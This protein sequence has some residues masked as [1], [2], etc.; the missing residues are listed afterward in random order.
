MELIDR[1]KLC[2]KMRECHITYDDLAKVLGITRNSVFNKIS[3]KYDF[4]ESE[5]A[6]LQKRFG[7]A[8]F[9]RN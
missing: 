6:K 5:I 1:D 7:K 9:V 3:G 4:T 2:G 8:I